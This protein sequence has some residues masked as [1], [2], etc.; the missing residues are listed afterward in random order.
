MYLL[1]EVTHLIMSSND[2]SLEVVIFVAGQTFGLLAVALTYLKDPDNARAA[3][4]QALTLDKRDPAIALN[5]A[6]FLY[7]LEQHKESIEKL[8][9]FE[10]RV[11]ALRE[12]GMETD[13]DIVK[14]A[15]GLCK[16]LNYDMTGLYAVVETKEAIDFN[17]W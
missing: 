5:Y 4:N 2:S 3:Y 15:L 9:L 6:I 11:I 17:F 10:N 12:Q 1:Q 16:E 7:N 14:A 8:S 13:A